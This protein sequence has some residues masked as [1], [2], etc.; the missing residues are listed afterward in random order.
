MIKRTL[1]FGNPAHL[2]VKNEQ[3]CIELKNEER[4]TATVPIEDLGM[5]VVEHPQITFTMGVLDAL[6]A[7]KVALITC[8]KNYL[9]NGMLLPFEANSEQNKRMRT[10]LDASTPL[11]KQLWQQTIKQKIQNQANVLDKLGLNATRLHTLVNKVQSGDSGNLEAQAAAYYWDTLYGN[12]FT[13]GRSLESPNAQLNYG[14]AIL[15]SMVAR[16]LVASGMLPT[17]GIF[18]A[19]KYNA[20]CLA[21]DIME[22]FR[23]FVDWVVLH[24]EG[25][26]NLDAGLTREQKIELLKLPQMDIVVNDTKSP[27]FHAISKTTASLFKC[28]DGELRKICYPTFE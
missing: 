12:N 21:D 28:F 15:R 4:T 22:P 24:L 6:M 1:H 5:V 18:H 7:N 19:N 17:I 8:D 25:I 26:Q 10:Q 2:S 14:Y 23:P 11:K 3:L 9:P 16:A 20:F 13:R 27:M